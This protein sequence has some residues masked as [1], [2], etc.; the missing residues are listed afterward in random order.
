MAGLTLCATRQA[1]GIVLL[2]FY[3]KGRATDVCTRGDFS[4]IIDSP[5]AYN[6]WSWARLQQESG[7]PS[8]QAP[9]VGSKDPSTEAITCCLTG[10]Q[11]A[12]TCICSGDV[13]WLQ[14][15]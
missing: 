8:F 6:G 3:L 10:H 11:L 15:L 1:P 9:P 14:V 4:S 13:T 5:N 7:T 2:K 12:G